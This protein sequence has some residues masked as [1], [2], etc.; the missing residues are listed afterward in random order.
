MSITPQDPQSGDETNYTPNWIKMDTDY[1]PGDDEL[2]ENELVPLGDDD[3]YPELD[4]GENLD[5]KNAE[6]MR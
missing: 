5:Y 4:P 3:L 6:T 2:V 1:P